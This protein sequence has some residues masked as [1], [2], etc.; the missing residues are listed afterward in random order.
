MNLSNLDCKNILIQ[1]DTISDLILNPNKYSDIKINVTINDCNTVYTNQC[2]PFN[3]A[4]RSSS[5]I[6][7]PNCCGLKIKSVFAKMLLT[8]HEFE[9]PIQNG[10]IQN[11]QNVVSIRN[12]VNSFLL[13]NYGRNNVLISSCNFDNQSQTF[14]L[15]LLS[16]SQEVV[17]TKI[18]Y[19]LDGFEIE[20]YLEIQNQINF[21][22]THQGIILYPDFF[23]TEVLSNGIYSIDVI[24]TTVNGVEI[25]ESNCL[26]VDCG[27]DCL[28]TE[29][30]STLKDDNEKKDLLLLHYALLAGSN[31]GCNCDEL[32][33]LYKQLAKQIGDENRCGTC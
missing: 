29:K 4:C 11:C 32:V 13:G 17:F 26:F 8:Q 10:T 6:V 5:S 1:S 14:T 24:L 19:E 3:L 30:A 7:L 21:A 23:L 20:G 12:E 16:N 25:T 33:E 9:I 2:T 28:L 27:L 18:V 15:N 22:I 31:C